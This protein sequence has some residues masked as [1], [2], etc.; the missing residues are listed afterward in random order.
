MTKFFEWK[1]TVRSLLKSFLKIVLVIV[2]LCALISF[3]Y[4]IV[5]MLSSKTLPPIPTQ[6]VEV[7]TGLVTLTVFVNAVWGLLF[8]RDI[9]EVDEVSAFD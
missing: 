5:W 2:S 6:P 7:F 3:V 8:G 9:E 1:K 4:T